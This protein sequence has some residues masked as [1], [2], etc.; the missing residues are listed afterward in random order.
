MVSIIDEA[1]DLIGNIDS[2]WVL[3]RSVSRATITNTS[4]GRIMVIGTP[5]TNRSNSVFIG[6]YLGIDVYKTDNIKPINVMDE[7]V[8]LL[9]L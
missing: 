1:S 4:N 8:H 9:D 7:P 6:S 5:T 2:D 3:N